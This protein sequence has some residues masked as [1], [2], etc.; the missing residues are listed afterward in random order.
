MADG[1]IHL[2]A[3]WVRSDRK[4]DAC[5]LYIHGAPNRLF[6]FL[7]L[8]VAGTLKW[9]PWIDPDDLAQQTGPLQ[10]SDTSEVEAPRFVG[11]VPATC[12]VS[13][14]VINVS[15]AEASAG[16]ILE[17][18]DPVDH[19]GGEFE[20]AGL[21]LAVERVDLHADPEQLDN[22]VVEGVADGAD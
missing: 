17:R 1:N 5:L 10:G 21:F 4:L 9:A 22:G 19:P 12:G 16:W 3:S 11:L 20:S 2:T 7:G 13:V 18:R 6:A 14:Y 15:E 8:G